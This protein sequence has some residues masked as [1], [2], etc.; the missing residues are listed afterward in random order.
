MGVAPGSVLGF[1]S[2]TVLARERRGSVG[3]EVPSCLL[4]GTPHLC[5]FPGKGSAQGQG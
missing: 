3:S 5:V 4:K 1:E 2:T